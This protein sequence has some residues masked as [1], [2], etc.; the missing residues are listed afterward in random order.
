MPHP[1]W[2][3]IMSA[4]QILANFIVVSWDNFLS[5]LKNVTEH[6]RR[7]YG[8]GEKRRLQSSLE[9]ADSFR[10]RISI[11]TFPP[12]PVVSFIHNQNPFGDKSSQFIML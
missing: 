12:C 9:I 3:L 1:H 8:E 11:H 2:D 4:F 6:S 7:V 5:Q 10:N